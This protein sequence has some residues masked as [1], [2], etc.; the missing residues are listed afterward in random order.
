MNNTHGDDE[1]NAPNYEEDEM[2]CWYQEE[3]LGVSSKDKQS[4]KERPSTNQSKHTH[5]Q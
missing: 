4:F 2:D 3:R 1:H 5:S